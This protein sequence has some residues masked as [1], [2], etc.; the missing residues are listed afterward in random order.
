MSPTPED[1]S[2]LSKAREHLKEGAA[3]ARAELDERLEGLLD[4][5][6][7]LLS[8][9]ELLIREKPLAAFGIAFAA[10]YLIAALTR[11]R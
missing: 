8:Q 3:E 11:R 2:H 4:Q 10:G 5:G 1:A 6:R 9:A 7:G